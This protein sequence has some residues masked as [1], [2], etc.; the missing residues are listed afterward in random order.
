MYTIGIFPNTK[1]KSVTSVLNQIVRY[2]NEKN[3]NVVLP[4]REACDIGFDE[5]AADDSIWRNADFAISLGGD[6]TLLS[7]TRKVASLGKPIFGINMGKLGFLTEV[8]VTGLNKAIDNMLQG[9]FVIEERTML[10]AVV[11]R[12]QKKLFI[13]SAVNDVVV[14]K[15]G[16]SRMIKLL[17]RINKELVASYLADG[18]IVA[19]PTGSTAYSLSAGG[20]I[21]KA[22]LDVILLTPIC[23][24]T[25]QSRPLVVSSEEEISI[26]APTNTIGD[27][28]I[29]V[30]GQIVENL[31][32]G[33]T[34][35]IER[36]PY[37]AKFIRFNDRHYYQRLHKKLWRDEYD[38]NV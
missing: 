33:D 28:I 3:I 16:Y 4:R 25:L 20:P 6:G 27:L 31:L 23:A 9:N 38:E 26:A 1:K 22:D 15:A 19:T 11:L 8:E 32:P 2:C 34:V 30:D 5:L 36:T 29:T 17:L 10:D 12:Q 24:H 21:I 14:T 35:L 37:K 18:I 13:S 7:A